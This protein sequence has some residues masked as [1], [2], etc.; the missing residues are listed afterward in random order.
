ML[1]K[2][3]G[4]LTGVAVLVVNYYK[5]IAQRHVIRNTQD[6]NIEDRLC[7]VSFQMGQSGEF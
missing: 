3:G 4:I 2:L 5:C 1:C 6:D 7:Y